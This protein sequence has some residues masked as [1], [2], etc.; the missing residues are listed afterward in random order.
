M[1]EKAREREKERTS[2]GE[3]E[4]GECAGERERERERLQMTERG[5]GKGL[6]EKF[7]SI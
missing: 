4:G 2:V 3:R 7:E 5:G 1:C 6:E